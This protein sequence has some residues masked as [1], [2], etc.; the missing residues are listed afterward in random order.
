MIQRELSTLPEMLQGKGYRTAAIGKYHV[1][2]S[3]ADAYGEIAN[4]FDFHDVDFTL[5]ILDGPTHH[6]FDEFF[7]VPGNT[8]DSLDTEPRVYIRDDQWVL[9]DRSKMKLIGM[10]KRAN[11]IIADPDW[12]LEKLGPDFLRE[13][14][15]FIDRQSQTQTDSP[16][17]LYYVPCANHLQRNAETGHY[18]VPDSIAG[19]PVKGQSRY[20]DDTPGSDREDMVIE[21]DIAFGEL[22][23][24]LKSTGDP[25]NPGHK[26]IDN[27]LVIF[28]SDNGSNTGINEERNQESGGLRGKKAKIYE[29]GIRVPFI[30]AFPGK[31]KA[32]AITDTVSTHTDLYATLAKVVGHDLQPHE[33]H[34]SLDC[35]SHWT[36]ETSEPDN[37]ARV[38]FCHL[39]PPY[40]NDVL[41]MRKGMEK[42]FIKG[43]LAMPWITTSAGGG[44]IPNRYYDLHSDPYEDGGE[45]S[46]GQ[47]DR[48]QAL[49]DELLKIHNRGYR[50]DLHLPTEGNRLVL[51]S[52]WHNLRNDV[53]GEIGF[54]FK[55]V[56][57]GQ[58][59]SHLGMW[60]NHNKDRPSR[61]A[62]DEP[63]EFTSDQKGSDIKSRQLKAEHRVRLIDTD[64]DSTIAEVT[65][66][67]SAGGKIEE[68]F[69]YIELSESLELEAGKTYTLLMSTTAGDG[70]YFRDHL[71]FDGL[72]PLMHPDFEVLRTLFLRQGIEMPM[73]AYRDLASDTQRHRFPVGP[74]FKWESKE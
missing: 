52:G 56:K 63:T 50:R 11:R 71:S 41:V 55:A 28:T 23:A 66:Q 16:F 38:F 54:Q 8:E 49:A 10:E 65:F 53:T 40:S 18:C 70:D 27:T 26:L 12:H 32:G 21:N 61:P 62:R 51:D 31:L 57:G 58:K 64:S 14:L 35:W 47:A 25:R 22:L 2:M 68:Q 72:S 29:G 44:S 37:R 46:P 39:G 20:T 4:D 15:A 60:S 6:G 24:K 33:A 19:Q 30:A 5:P 36:G 74:T 67:P 7:G 42:L 59:I 1:G 45:I 73:P 34:D 13:A 3:F 43:G 48:A 17:L 69:R 9:K